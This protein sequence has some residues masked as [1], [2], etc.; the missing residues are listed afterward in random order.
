MSTA[1]PQPTL[2]GRRYRLQNK[3]GQGGMGAVYHA[4]DRLTGAEVAL[5][6][7]RVDTPMLNA[8]RHA[9]Q[10]D[11]DPLLALANEFQVMASLRHPNIVSVYDYGF[12][13]HGQPYFTMTLL[14]GAQ[15]I[16]DAARG[17][18]QPAQ[19]DLLIQTLQALAYIHRRGILHRDLKPSNVLVKEGTVYVV[20]FGL[21]QEH[22]GASFAPIAGTLAYLA[23]E[24]LAEVPASR[25]SDLY[26]LGVI[27]Y[28]VLAGKHPFEGLSVTDLI[29]SISTGE[30][31]V[32]SLD[33]E[34]H[35]KAVLMR[36]LQ[37]DPTLRYQSA[38]AVLNE[39]T[40]V[41]N[42]SATQETA[43]IRESYLQAARFVGREQELSQLR[44]AFESLGSRGSGWLIGGESGVGKSRLVNELRAQALVNG[45]LV[46]VGQG[47]SDGG[48]P[49][50][51]WRDIARRLAL[52]GEL[53]DT[54]AAALRQVVPDIETLIEQDVPSLTETDPAELQRQLFQAMESL[55]RQALATQPVLIILEDLQWAAESLAV[56]RALIPLIAE[57]P[58]MIIGT[59]RDDESP[60]LPDKLPSFQV[61]PLRRLTHDEIE[62]LSASML[63][64]AGVRPM[65]VDL[66][67][68][69]TEG[70]VF[71]LVEVVRALAQEAGS[72]NDIGL[73]TLPTNVM[74]GGIQRI[75]HYRLERVP[76]WARA[77][78]DVAAVFGRRVDEAVMRAAAPDL[79][80]ERWLQ[81]CADAA[82]LEVSDNAYRF[83]HD[84]LREGV[85][86]ELDDSRRVEVNRIVAESVERA[87]PD[88]LTDYALILSQHWAAAGDDAKEAHYSMIAAH[89]SYERDDYI[90]AMQLYQRAFALNAPQYAANPDKTL[91]DLYFG[92]GRACFSLSDYQGVIDWQTQALEQYR[93]IGD[94]FGEADAIYALGEVD[95]RQSRYDIARERIQQSL[96]IFRTLDAPKKSAYALMTLG[97]IHTQ[98]DEFDKSIAIFEECLDMM[99]A[100]GDQRAVG[101]VLNNMAI[102][103][104][105]SGDLERALGIY[106]ESLDLRRTLND[107][108]GIVYSLA[109]L[110]AINNDRG[111]NALALTQLEE[112]YQRSLVL[113]E[114]QTTATILSMLG[115][116]HHALG[117]YA[118][119][120]QTQNEALVMRRHLNDRRGICNSLISLALIACEQHRVE[121]ARVLFAELVGLI[122]VDAVM[123]RLWAH[124]AVKV[125]AYIAEEEGDIA[126]AVTLL[127]AVLTIN[128]AQN[129]LSM[130]ESQEKLAALV[131]KLDAA[132][133]THARESGAAL[134]LEAAFTLA[135]QGVG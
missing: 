77:W 1:Q 57:L 135:A 66:L 15:S 127:S 63:G 22:S 133:A 20:D 72:L 6:Q 134:T 125:A 68:R 37:K 55:L 39:L 27:A 59:Y 73:V 21:A 90:N 9:S 108:M 93:R 29:I 18:P 107:R 75:V 88:S 71:F 45:A 95:L 40:N 51:L 4:H 130:T 56:L 114:R 65:I 119:A 113:G 106:Q 67:E 89:E 53:S 23:P 34:P 52:M 46:L 83:A 74:S 33:L 78:L 25:A 99:R 101:R 79:D 117:H 28:E 69:E 87:Y 85:L 30:I 123:H 38:E 111:E 96:D 5:K 60:H 8:I 31:D 54:E 12:D 42:A 126:R 120:E 131:A 43:E 50:Q 98:S 32:A 84:K 104:D 103:Y 58:L 132:S 80:L 10:T 76:L 19:I 109:N 112:A 128:A 48:L 94:R 41:G 61:L 13:T 49:Y 110:G 16:T 86:T 115:Q 81:A 121:H 97:V 129:G 122:R 11:E 26:A 47:V 3:L 14:D 2:L 24:I 92:L 100:I 7:L 36:V 91:A 124:S 17:L 64:D 44:Q 62:R 118:E 70:N 35:L 102:A 116:V 105:M 82:V